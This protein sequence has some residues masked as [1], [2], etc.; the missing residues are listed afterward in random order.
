MAHT[1]LLPFRHSS[2][3]K[4]FSNVGIAVFTLMSLIFTLINPKLKIDSLSFQLLY[5]CSIYFFSVLILLIVHASFGKTIRIVCTTGIIIFFLGLSS[6]FSQQ[7]AIIFQIPLGNITI[8][9]YSI[10]VNRA[11]LIWV[12]GLLSVS[13][14]TLYST[15][16]TMQEFIQ[17][18]RNL[19][20]PRILVTLIMLIL[21]F[22]PI[23]YEQGTEV[24]TSQELRGLRTGSFNNRF[25]AAGARVGGTLIRSTRK[26]T[27]VYEAMV[28]RGLEY[29]QLPKRVTSRWWINTLFIGVSMGIYII[30]AGGLFYWIQ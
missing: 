27:E 6:L 8:N 22:T 18:L 25:R 20:F 4:K 26:G 30:I 28:T 15:T 29:A 2:V 12:R 11:I 19:F 5:I 21:R 9:F 23:L 10:G 13:I 14:V 7:G 16:L 1:F 24:K 3:P 17:T